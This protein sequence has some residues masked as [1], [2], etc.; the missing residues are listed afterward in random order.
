VAG[1]VALVVALAAGFLIGRSVG[2]GEEAPTAGAVRG[3]GCR[4]ALSLSLQVVEL[5][6]QAIANRTQIAQAVAL[7]DGGQVRELTSAFEALAPAIQEAE[8]QL[9]AA[10]EKCGSRAGGGKGKRRGGKGRGGG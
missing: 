5:Q 9:A 10:A 7:E 3:G 2:G 8:T 1:V 4:K 6:K